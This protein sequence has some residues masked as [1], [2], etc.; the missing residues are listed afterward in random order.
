MIEL[1]DLLGF[2]RKAIIEGFGIFSLSQQSIEIIFRIHITNNS[3]V[4][5]SNNNINQN[6]DVRYYLKNENKVD[7]QFNSVETGGTGE[8]DFFINLLKSVPLPILMIQLATK[9]NERGIFD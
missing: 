2:K 5:I 1:T 8:Y 9:L 6:R 7:S 4:L 3:G